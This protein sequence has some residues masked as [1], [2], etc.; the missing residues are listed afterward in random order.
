MQTAILIA[1]ILAVKWIDY[2]QTLWILT[3]GQEHG[4]R[5]LNPLITRPSRVLPVMG[6][7]TAL[8]VA[9]G[10]FWQPILAVFLIGS[11]VIVYR[12]KR[13]GVRLA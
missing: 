11:A 4:F 10:L 9:A 3:E 8:A 2:R 7:L 6:G 12:N 13:I 5:E 1:A